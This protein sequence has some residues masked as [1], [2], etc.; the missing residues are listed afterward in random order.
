MLLRCHDHADII[1]ALLL[2]RTYAC[3]FNLGAILAMSHSPA[4][5]PVFLSRLPDVLGSSAAATAASKQASISS[6][7]WLIADQLHLADTVHVSCY[8]AAHS[9]MCR[10]AAG[11]AVSRE[12]GQVQTELYVADQRLQQHRWYSISLQLRKKASRRII[13][14]HQPIL[15][16]HAAVMSQ[17][18]A[19]VTTPDT[20]SEHILTLLHAEQQLNIEGKSACS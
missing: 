15:R 7:A 14:V 1:A 16:T 12:R 10:H 3:P 11:I 5:N 19:L 13:P 2:V 8:S 17:C 18:W 6:V 20:Y 9:Y 4:A